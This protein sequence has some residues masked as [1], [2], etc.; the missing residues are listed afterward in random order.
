MSSCAPSGSSTLE[1]INAIETSANERDLEGM[2][3]LFATDAVVNESFMQ[4][5]NVY[6][7]IGEEEIHR[8]WSSYFQFPLTHEFR[9]ISVDGDTA[10]FGWVQEDPV[11]TKLYPV[12]IE[13][14]NGQITY[15][16]FYEESTILPNG[17][18]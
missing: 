7:Y 14:Q 11:Y 18:E 10:T 12:R 2:M 16:D 17:D 6:I 8:F 5:E 1:I 3:A 13:V 9:D 15:L 4:K